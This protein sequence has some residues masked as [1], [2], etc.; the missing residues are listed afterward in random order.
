MQNQIFMNMI[1]KWNLDRLESLNR[2]L[3]YFPNTV[4]CINKY[5]M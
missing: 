3:F 4:M 2:N 5:F 1:K